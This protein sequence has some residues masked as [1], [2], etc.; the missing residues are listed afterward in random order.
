MRKADKLPAPTVEKDTEPEE[1]VRV[2][3]QMVI[4]FEVEEA[5]DVA[6]LMD[7]HRDAL[8]DALSEGSL[9]FELDGREW[10]IYP[11]AITHVIVRE[12]EDGEEEDYTARK[13]N[14]FEADEAPKEDKGNSTLT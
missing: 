7:C 2:S 3:R 13:I 4:V 5:K 9:V 1:T 10:T 8:I 14:T 12:L 6:E 11:N